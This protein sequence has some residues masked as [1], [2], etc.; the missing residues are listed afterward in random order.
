MAAFA[1]LIAGCSIPTWQPVAGPVQSPKGGFS[2]QLPQG[3]AY[4]NAS[5]ADAVISSREGPGLQHIRAW[6]HPLAD[7]M[8]NSKDTV[9]S[10]MT[11]EQLADAVYE[12]MVEVEGADLMEI[13][14]VAPA[15]LAGNDGFRLEYTFTHTGGPKCRSV[16]FGAIKGDSLYLIV[17]RAPARFYFDRDLADFEKAVQSLTILKG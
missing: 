6:V 8:P 5:G 1:L 13:A 14:S 3:W 16:L 15:T 12:E 9:S 4:L 2:V 17:Y 7:P 11:T 10:D